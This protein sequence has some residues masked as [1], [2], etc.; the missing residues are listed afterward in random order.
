MVAEAALERLRSSLRQWISA[1]G[2]TPAA[3]SLRIGR[4]ASYLSRVLAG[5]RPLKLEVLFEA[6]RAFG[7]D[8]REFFD[9]SFPLGGDAAYY[10]RYPSRSASPALSVLSEAARRAR[11]VSGYYDRT[12]A[13]HVSKL[14]QHLRQV[15]RRERRSQR[16]VSVALGLRRDSLGLALRGNTDL[17]SFHLLGTL[18]ILE[19]SPARFFTELFTVNAS[20][21]VDGLR[22][23]KMVAAL[24]VALSKAALARVADERAETGPQPARR[25]E[26]PLPALLNRPRVK[27]D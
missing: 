4:D 12:P 15:L 13:D 6:L 2:T 5:S 3:L 9:M 20:R 17:T 14:A 16:E 27:E 26:V 1:Y 22:S 10:L 19:I 18:E 25:A 7:G 21:P 23:A 11:E 24:E 8:P